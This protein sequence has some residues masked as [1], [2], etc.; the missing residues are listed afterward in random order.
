LSHAR[1][2][3]GKSRGRLQ[4]RRV[5][6]TG[7]AS[8][9]GRQL[10]ADLYL[11]EGCHLLLVDRDERGLS[12]LAGELERHRTTHEGSRSIAL[13]VLDVASTAE[14]EAFAARLG[15]LPLDGLVNCAGTLY[16]GPFE[17]MRID[18]FERVIGVNFL[19]AVRLTR[20]LLPRLF[21]GEDGFI[22]NLASAAGLAGAPG[23]AAYSASKFALLG[24]SEALRAELRGRISVCVVC[25]S[26]VRTGIVAHAQVGELPCAPEHDYRAAIG[27]V[28]ERFGASPRKVSQAIIDA[29]MRQRSLVLVN[30]DAHALYHS[31]R[32]FPR[33][34]ELVVS[35]GYRWLQRR[36]VLSP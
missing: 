8:G 26:I 36:G 21:A 6:V 16:L 25:P 18:D 31:R 22:V 34:T 1:P 17:R 20:A 28:L 2:R 10:A 32:F 29:I 33:L 35:Q 4:G 24:F 7:A 30:L 23:M 14:V 27:A 13:H 3:G 19:G 11:E 15:E 12:E 9:I 5:L